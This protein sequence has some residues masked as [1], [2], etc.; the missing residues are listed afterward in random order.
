MEGGR[1]RRD[2]DWLEECPVVLVGDGDDVANFD[3]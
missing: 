2:E 1:D 3:H